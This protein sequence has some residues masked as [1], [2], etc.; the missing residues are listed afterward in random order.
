MKIRMLVALAAIA[1]CPGSAAPGA[2]GQSEPAQGNVEA[3]RSMALLA[4][5]GCH[6]VAPD[7]PFK[8]VRVGPLQPPDFKDIANRPGLTA[9]SLRHHLETLPDVPQNAHMPNMVLSSEELRD[10][11]AFILSL[12]DQPPPSR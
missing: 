9:D 3:G 1:L 4:C 7:Q 8:P 2:T 5:T 6:I 12:R 11:V 10:V